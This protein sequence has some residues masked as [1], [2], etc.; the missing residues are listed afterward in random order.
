MAMA[1]KRRLLLLVVVFF[2]VQTSPAFAAEKKGDSLNVSSISWTTATHTD[3][4]HSGSE[5]A[6]F[7]DNDADGGFGSLDSMLQWA[8]GHSDPV[9]L[10]GAARAVQNLS[11]PELKARGS[12][13]ME[14]MESLRMPSDTDLMKAAIADLQNGTSSLEDKRRALQELLELVEPI[15]NSDDFHKLG[16]LVVVVNELDR[17]E[18]DLRILAA[19]VLGKA[20]QN[21]E[22]V[23]NQ[24]LELGVIPTLMAMTRSNSTEEAVKALYALSAVIRN[25]PLGQEQ[26]YSIE[27]A[28]LLEDLMRDKSS[29]M[30]LRRKALFLVADLAEQQKQS[31]GVLAEHEPSKSYLMAVVR[32]VEAEDLDIQEKALMAIHS[33]GGSSE[34]VRNLLKHECK[35]ESAL[36]KLQL[37]L[38]VLRQSENLSDFTEDLEL[39]CQKVRSIFSDEETSSE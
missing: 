19:W 28:S 15:F 38:D 18:Q 31:G 3:Y 14:I 29:D 12:A 2:F 16:G 39:L 35:V 1:M 8:I 22:V 21:N 11:A 30:R 9:T 27:G 24:L 23:Q 17:M 32:L 5:G 13:I 36:R 7:D 10:K 20:S 34:H 33:L 37:R 4:L 6:E 25:H 26:F